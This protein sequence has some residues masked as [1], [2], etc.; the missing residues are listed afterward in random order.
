MPRD[1]PNSRQRR[2][3]GWDLCYSRNRLLQ[4]SRKN[5]ENKDTIVPLCRHNNDSLF[6]TATFQ[7][8]YAI[9][10]WNQE[11]TQDSREAFVKLQ[12][13]Y[14]FVIYIRS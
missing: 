10:P 9:Y 6:K 14:F 13:W 12:N 1:V 8:V 2:L 7:I 11:G 4:W 5:N 3:E